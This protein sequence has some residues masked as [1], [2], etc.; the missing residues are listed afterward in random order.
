MKDEFHRRILK[1]NFIFALFSPC[2][3]RVWFQ[4]ELVV[5][6]QGEMI[7]S[8]VQLASLVDHLNSRCLC[9][10]AD[11]PY[12][13]DTPMA[14]VLMCLLIPKPDWRLVTASRHNLVSFYSSFITTSFYRIQTAQWR[15]VAN[16]DVIKK[17][18]LKINPPLQGRFSYFER[19]EFIYN[20]WNFKLQEQLLLSLFVFSWRQLWSSFP[21][22]VNELKRK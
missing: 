3:R 10:A 1:S 21:I 9:P 11:S 7:S 8:R 18:C 4:G 17:I 20:I 2:K 19:D 6:L 15:K 12:G 5:F 13:W 16:S 22:F 14:H